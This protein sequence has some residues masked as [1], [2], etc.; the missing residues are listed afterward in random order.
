MYILI[1]LFAED[2]GIIAE[3]AVIGIINISFLFVYLRA[4]NIVLKTSNLFKAL[5]KAFTTLEERIKKRWQV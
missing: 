1:A 4:P 2:Y 3:L 5:I